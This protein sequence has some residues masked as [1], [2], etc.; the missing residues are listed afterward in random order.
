MGNIRIL[1]RGREN[2]EVPIVVMNQ[3]SRNNQN[4]NTFVEDHHMACPIAATL[5]L[6][7]L[8]W[9]EF[10]YLVGKKNEMGKWQINN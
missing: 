6:W 5:S 2:S 7:D 3:V 4:Y 10:I 8:W 9:K 1:K